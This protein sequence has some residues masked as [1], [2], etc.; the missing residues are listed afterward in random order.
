MFRLLAVL[1][2]LLAVPALAQQFESEPRPKEET[3]PPGYLA[4]AKVDYRCALPIPPAPGSAKEQEERRVVE[5]LQTMDEA[6]WRSAEL[7]ARYLFPRFAEAFGRDINRKEIPAT[8]RLLSR[9][10]RDVAVTT[11]EAKDHFG[12]PRPYQTFQLVRVCGAEK[13]PAPDAEPKSR[14]SY[15]SGH[16]SYGWA[17]AMILA[18]LKAERAEK[19]MTSAREYG[20]SRAICGMHYP[21][22]VNAGHVIAAAVISRL[23]GNA[24]FLADLEGARAELASPTK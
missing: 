8:V 13:A 9:A 4:P 3:R 23:E 6:R 18:R 20:E 15:P 12:R 2:G 16:S 11:F 7:D 24:E 19:L 21:S 5:A 17:T 10:M 1:T 14:S 22:D